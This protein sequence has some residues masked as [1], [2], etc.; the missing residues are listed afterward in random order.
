MQDIGFMK[1]L[2]IHT[3]TSSDTRGAPLRGYFKS[4]SVYKIMCKIII[5]QE[6]LKPVL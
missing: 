1:L 6:C 5:V 4:R 2:N 3:A